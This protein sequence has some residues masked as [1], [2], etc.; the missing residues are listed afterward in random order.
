MKNTFTSDASPLSGK[1]QRFRL[2]EYALYFLILAT[3]L[4]IPYFLGAFSDMG[5][6]RVWVDWFRLLPFILIFVVNNFLLVPKLLFRDKY[7]SYILSAAFTIIAVIYLSFL[8]FDFIRPDPVSLGTMR[9]TSR[10]NIQQPPFDRMREFR[11]DSTGEMPPEGRMRAFPPDSMRIAPREG[12]MIVPP[13][14]RPEPAAHLLAGRMMRPF[15]SY[16]SFIVAILLIGFNTGVKSFTRWSEDKVSRAEK[17][18]QYYSA[19][20]AMLKHQISPHFLM[21]TLN[22]IH[23][24][25]DINT[26]EAKNAIIRLSRL[27]RYLLYEGD[28]QHVSLQKE[29]NFIKSYIELMRLRYDEDNLAIETEYP[30]NTENIYVPS[31]LFLTFIE[32]AFKHGVHPE[33][34]SLIQIKFAIEN[35]WLTFSVVNSKPEMPAL[36][37]ETSGIGLDNVRKRLSL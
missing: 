18:R 4:G 28:V 34:R 10:E 24:L 35:H 17:E 25:V 3:A 31:S 26:E 9:E 2:F 12:R 22:N 6:R 30:V 37:T 5:L 23:A 7:L 19:E 11:R 36:Q 14:G 32:N 8:L 20:L 21:N 15:F 13:F 16:G 1:Q 33:I 29:I 27:M